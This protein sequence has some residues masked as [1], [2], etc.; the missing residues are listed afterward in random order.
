[1][2]ERRCHAGR[3]HQGGN[4]V[5][6]AII[7]LSKKEQTWSSPG[8]PNGVGATTTTP[9]ARETTQNAAVVSTGQSR[10]RLSLSPK[11]NSSQPTLT[12]NVDRPM[13]KQHVHHD[14]IDRE[15]N[16]PASN[17]PT[18]RRRRRKIEPTGGDSVA[19]ATGKERATPV[20]DGATTP[21]R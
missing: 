7:C 15:R 14:D 10:A 18:G 4:D 17:D 9:P 5:N 8:K 13:E 11:T 16:R 1:V 2:V 3:C 6:A 20:E 21:T 19:T 12:W